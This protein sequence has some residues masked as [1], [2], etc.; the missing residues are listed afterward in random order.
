MKGR[1]YNIILVIVLLML[2]L[3]IFLLYYNL[4]KPFINLDFLI[5]TNQMKK[6]NDR[7]IQEIKTGKTQKFRAKKKDHGE[8]I[9]LT[10]N[11]ND[12]IISHCTNRLYR[13]LSKYHIHN[14]SYEKFYYLMNIVEKMN[15]FEDIGNT[16]IIINKKNKEGVEHFDH[17]CKDW[18]SEFIWIRTNEDKQFYIKDNLGFKHYVNCNIMWFD[19]MRKHNITPINKDCFSIRIDG[20]FNKS[21]REYMYKNAPFKNNTNREAFLVNAKNIQV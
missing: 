6:L 15:I 12:A 3:S 18:V 11:V 20:K 17:N 16:V 13:G 2:F 10:N 14:K 7:L 1:K 21:F 19:D 8:K 4:H 5:T 9:A